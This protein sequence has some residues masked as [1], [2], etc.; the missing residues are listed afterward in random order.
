[1]NSQLP[2]QEQ[3]GGEESEIKPQRQKRLR[4][5]ERGEEIIMIMETSV[6]HFISMRENLQEI[7]NA[8]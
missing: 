3:I 4:E 5:R 8:K 2:L 7:M 1:M 6:K